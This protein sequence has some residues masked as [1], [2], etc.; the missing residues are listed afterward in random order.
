MLIPLRGGIISN[1]G[2]GFRASFMICEIF[3][4]SVK[5]HN[6]IVDYRHVL[7][8]AED[9]TEV[10]SGTGRNIAGGGYTIEPVGLEGKLE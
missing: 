8:V 4:A 10:E 9:K 2:N 1:D 5:K 7:S 3:I 6:V